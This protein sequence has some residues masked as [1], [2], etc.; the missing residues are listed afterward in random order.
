[1]TKYLGIPNFSM[2]STI[3]QTILV[4]VKYITRSYFY[5]SVVLGMG[6]FHDSWQRHA[7]QL[8]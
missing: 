5:L 4:G 6:F 3:L 2:Q 7:Q 8:I 1:M